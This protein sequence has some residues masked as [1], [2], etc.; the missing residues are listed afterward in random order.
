M[1]SMKRVSVTRILSF[2]AA[3]HEGAKSRRKI[4]S[5]SWLFPVLSCFAFVALDSPASKQLAKAGTTIIREDTLNNAVYFLSGM[6]IDA[7]G[8]PRAYHPVSDSGQDALKNAGK[9]GNWFGIVTDKN[10]EP[11][12]QVKNDPAPGFYISCTS[13]ADAT[14]KLTDQ[15]RYVNSD[16]IPYIVLP[17]IKPGLAEVKMGDIAFVKNLR[18]GKT[19]FA[20]C[21][22]VGPKD[23][24]GEG[25]MFLAR[26]LG[27]NASPRNGGVNDSILYIIFPKSGNRM[28]MNRT[29]IDF[30]GQL[31]YQQGMDSVF[32]R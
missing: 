4:K 2:W 16:S 13:L 27:I 15:T 11:V 7:D 30:I 9:K 20:I 5:A 31:R 14:K 26:T 3:G 21:A 19:S 18:N 1:I 25:S 32:I 17:N 23:E 10:G 28:P 24:A 12:V 22:D 29:A 8:S 6:N